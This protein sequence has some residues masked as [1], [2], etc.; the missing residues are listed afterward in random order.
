M[1]N[2]S[3]NYIL[4]PWTT[5]CIFWQYL[6]LYR[7]KIIKYSEFHCRHF[8]YFTALYLETILAGLLLSDLNLHITPILSQ[9]NLSKPE[10]CDLEAI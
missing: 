5:Y 1:E 10:I 8:S 6:F 2:I 7:N 3:Q 4:G 9:R